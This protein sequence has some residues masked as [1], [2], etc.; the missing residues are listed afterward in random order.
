MHPGRLKPAPPDPMKSIPTEWLVRCKPNIE[1]MAIQAACKYV[2][3]WRLEDLQKAGFEG[4]KKAVHSGRYN[5]GLGS[6][7][8]QQAA[9]WI[10]EA[11][12]SAGKRLQ[13]SAD[14]KGQPEP[15]NAQIR[16]ALE[17]FSVKQWQDLIGEFELQDVDTLR[18]YLTA[19]HEPLTKWIGWPKYAAIRDGEITRGFTIT[20][21]QPMRMTRITDAMWAAHIRA[22]S[23]YHNIAGDSRP[24]VKRSWA[25]VGSR[26]N[27]AESLS[28]Q[29]GGEVTPYQVGKMFER[30]EQVPFEEFDGDPRDY[31]FWATDPKAYEHNLRLRTSG[32][33]WSRRDPDPFFS[34]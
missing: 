6:P 19:N 8:E 2:L 15:S 5:E 17:T 26:N 27:I 9:R 29:G 16:Q 18:A 10:A 11:V 23:R 22:D 7:F 14:A 21:S 1:R 24:S 33:K 34:Q 31:Y 30:M 12:D 3:P 13:A 4:I 32:R 28:Q 25:E 20:F